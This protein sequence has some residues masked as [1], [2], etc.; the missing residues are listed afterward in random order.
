MVIIKNF[1]E[2]GKIKMKIK[3]EQPIEIEEGKHEG[4]ISKVVENPITNEKGEVVYTYIDTFV[5]PKDKGFELKY[6]CPAQITE[7]TKL[8]RLLSEF[9]EL[10]VDEE[11][12]PE[13]ILKDKKVSFVVVKR[14][15]KEGKEYSQI[16]D[17]S[18]KNIEPKVTEEKVEDEEVEKKDDK[19]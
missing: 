13:E 18:I 3:V 8:G 14:K 11:L 1:N 19:K 16:A 5:K 2:G 12:D 4:T 17:D 10:K 6:G 7:K 9:T 15:N